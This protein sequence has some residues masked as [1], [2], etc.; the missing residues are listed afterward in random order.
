MLCF[1]FKFTLVLNSVLLFW[2]L[3]VFQ[4][5]LGMSDA[6]LYSMSCSSCKNCSSAMS[7]NC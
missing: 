4:F 7:I 5:V 6:L 2:K 3:L 1:I